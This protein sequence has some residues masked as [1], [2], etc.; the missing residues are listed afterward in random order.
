[1]NFSHMCIGGERRRG[2]K[3]FL[4]LFHYLLPMITQSK[5]LYPFDSLTLHP[6][7]FIPLLEIPTTER[8]HLHFTS[9]T[10]G[11]RVKRRERVG[12]EEGRFKVRP[13]TGQASLPAHK[14]AH[15]SL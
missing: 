10:H 9:S 5:R 1:M 4:V 7:P 3:R 15:C 8:I 6:W 12:E 2:V 13:I 11:R 14:S